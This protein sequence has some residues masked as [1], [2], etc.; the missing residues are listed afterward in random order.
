MNVLRTIEQVVCYRVGDEIVVGRTGRLVADDIRELLDRGYV[1]V[2]PRT[3]YVRL[4]PVGRN[5]RD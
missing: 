3:G 1:S 2:N 4:T 5:A